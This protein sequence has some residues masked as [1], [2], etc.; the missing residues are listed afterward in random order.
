MTV[1]DADDPRIHGYNARTIRERDPLAE[2][3]S[4]LIL[5]QVPFTYTMFGGNTV[6]QLR[7]LNAAELAAALRAHPNWRA[8]CVSGLTVEDV[9]EAMHR[10]VKPGHLDVAF[11][12][13]DEEEDGLASVCD[14]PEPHMDDAAAILAA[15]G[16]KR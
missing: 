16:D 7:D 4:A 6:T 8:I 9:A 5:E 15:L 10:W 12:D 11:D 14:G 13:W 1:T 2:A 3:L